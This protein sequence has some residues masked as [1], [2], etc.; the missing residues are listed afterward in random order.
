MSLNQMQES[1]VRR[2]PI[3]KNKFA[4]VDSETYFIL[5][6]ADHKWGISSHGYV[7]TSIEIDGKRK[8]LYLHKA[9]MPAP[10]GYDIDHI[11]RDKLDNRKVNL[12]ICSRSENLHNQGLRRNN[13]SGH[14]GV[15]FR[16]DNKKWVAQIGINGKNKNLGSY[17]TFNEAVRIYEKENDKFM[18]RGDLNG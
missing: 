12:R 5:M 6:L 15:Y 16:K 18:K 8:I 13:K 3:G 1:Q 4:L 11:N 17:L 14:K 2:I 7:R 10:E 9:I